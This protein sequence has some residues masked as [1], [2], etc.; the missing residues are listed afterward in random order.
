M[1][2]DGKIKGCL[3]YGLRDPQGLIDIAYGTGDVLSHHRRRPHYIPQLSLVRQRCGI[4]PFY[5]QR[6]RGSD[7]RPFRS[8]DDAE[9]ISETHN[10]HHPRDVM[11]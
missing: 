9:E 1:R 11:Q 4:R 3:M 5:R 2:L 7:C 10:L 6:L 8:C